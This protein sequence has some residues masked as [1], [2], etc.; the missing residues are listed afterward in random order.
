MSEYI[1][2]Y[3]QKPDY[4]VSGTTIPVKAIIKTAGEDLSEHAPVIL[5]D[6]KLTAVKDKATLTRLYGI[7]ADAAASGKDVAV[8]L[9][10]EFFGSALT[11][12]DGVTADDL[13]VAFRNIGIFLE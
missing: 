8:Y 9:T 10:G 5:A 7:T 6:G 3:E 1:K 13:E 4:F 2:T 11:L 12:P